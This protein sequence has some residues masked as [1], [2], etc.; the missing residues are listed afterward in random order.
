MRSVDWKNKGVTVQKRVNGLSGFTYFLRVEGRNGLI[1]SP[2]VYIF[3]SYHHPTRPPSSLCEHPLLSRGKY[4]HH[5][6]CYILHATSLLTSRLCTPRSGYYQGPSHGVNSI[7]LK[8]TL[9]VAP[10]LSKALR[11]TNTCSG[12]KY[13][14]RVSIGA[15]FT[16]SRQ[17]TFKRS[18][19]YIWLLIQQYQRK[20]HSGV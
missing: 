20:L 13:W 2:I 15:Q 6:F 16:G 5:A 9:H 17:W 7:K 10:T 19:W 4:T 3:I 18:L 8:S 14:S 11:M 1:R 12:V